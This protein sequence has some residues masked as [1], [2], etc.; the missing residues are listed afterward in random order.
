MS[1]SEDSKDSIAVKRKKLIMKLGLKCPESA[2]LENP[3]VQLEDGT[4]FYDLTD[5]SSEEE[6]IKRF[7]EFVA[8]LGESKDNGAEAKAHDVDAKAHGPEAKA[9]G[10]E[11]KAHGAEAKANGRGAGNFSEGA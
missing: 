7:G 1:D 5:A 3:V 4:W 6:Q 8:S 11:A 10:P 9:H 2:N